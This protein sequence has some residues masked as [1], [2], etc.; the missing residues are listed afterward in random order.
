[1]AGA[2]GKLTQLA[3]P[4]EDV[5]KRDILAR[6]GSVD[7]LGDRQLQ[8]DIRRQNPTSLDAALTLAMKLDV[9]NRG[10]ARDNDAPR[11]R[12]LRAVMHGC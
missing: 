3:Y 1:L 8:I 9:L 4:S 12:Y 6:D 10:A 2:D 7:A 11:P 5:A